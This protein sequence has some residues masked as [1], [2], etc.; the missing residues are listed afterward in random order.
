MKTESEIEN[1][2][3]HCM[4]THGAVSP[5]AIDALK[6]V[7]SLKSDEDCNFLFHLDTKK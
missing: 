4:G 1:M 2:L 5:S 6:W 3:K 7:L